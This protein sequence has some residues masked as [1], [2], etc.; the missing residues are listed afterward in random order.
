[1][2]RFY[3]ILI[4][5]KQNKSTQIFTALYNTKIQRKIFAPSWQFIGDTDLVKRLALH[6]HLYCSTIIW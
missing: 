6:T 2:P 3:I 1:M 4:L 5:R